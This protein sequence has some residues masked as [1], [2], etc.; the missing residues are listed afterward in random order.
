MILSTGFRCDNLL[1][2][3]PA[4]NYLARCGL[5]RQGSPHQRVG[6][7][8]IT[9]GRMGLQTFRDKFSLRFHGGIVPEV[10]GA[11]RDPRLNF[12]VKD[13]SAPTPYVAT[14][15]LHLG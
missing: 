13:P 1:G 14:V 7:Y 8:I 11:V 3:V 10:T 12:Q 15:L 4:R 6:E 9:G 2:V 5:V